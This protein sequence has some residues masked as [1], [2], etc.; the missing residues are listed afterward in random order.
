MPN[1]STK[2]FQGS[3]LCG[4]CGKPLAGTNPGHWTFS[5]SKNFKAFYHVKCLQD[6]KKTSPSAPSWKP[7][8]PASMPQPD[9]YE[10][11]PLTPQQMSD[12]KAIVQAHIKQDRF[13]GAIRTIRETTNKGLKEAKDLMEQWRDELNL[14]APIASF[15]PP[16]T[17][18]IPTPKPLVKKT[19]HF[20][21]D[22]LVKM[23]QIRRDDGHHEDIYIPGAP[24]SGKSFAIK[25]AAKT[26][27]SRYGYI[28]L[29]EATQP[30]QIFGYMDANGKYVETL[31]YKFY[32]DGGVLDIAELDNTNA[33]VFTLLN[34]ALDNGACSF[35]CGTVERH[36]DFIAIGNGNTDLRGPTNLFPGRQRQDA[37][38][39]ARF[40]FI[41]NW[42]YDAELEWSL[43]G[44]KYPKMV[45]WVQ[46]L[47]SIIEQR[48]EQLVAGT[49][50]M[51]KISGLLDAGF[52]SAESL[53]RGLFKNYQATKELL[54]VHPITF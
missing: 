40:T 49:R 36:K 26:L 27:E 1:I 46:K 17:A 25:Q 14:T 35:P 45:Q 28:A 21:F 33:N 52:S 16:I 8:T 19:H 22:D 50:E 39:I 53:H 44:E 31:L 24:G 29:S 18:P 47:R 42:D 5:T 34:N 43:Y 32:R 41:H 37:A 10:E 48:K 4:I 23:M 20:A 38:S 6:S 15:E 51:R 54:L 7:A 30:S 9:Q 3:A 2:V 13:I 11:I 12:L